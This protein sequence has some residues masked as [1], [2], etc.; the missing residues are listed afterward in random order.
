MPSNYG[1]WEPVYFEVP[2]TDTTMN[3]VTHNTTQVYPKFPMPRQPTAMTDMWWGATRQAS[4]YWH[5]DGKDYKNLRN[6]LASKAIQDR[7]NSGNY[8]RASRPHLHAQLFREYGH[9]LG[10]ALG[11][12]FKCQDQENLDA[13]SGALNCLGELMRASPYTRLHDRVVHKMQQTTPDVFVCECCN[14]LNVGER[15]PAYHRFNVFYCETCVDREMVVPL[16]LE[17][18][19]LNTHSVFRFRDFED[20]EE[21]P[22]AYEDYYV[23][24]DY[25]QS[26]TLRWAGSIER[27]ITRAVNALMHT[28]GP[29]DGR[30]Y[31]Y[32]DGPEMGHIPSAYDNRQPRVLMGLELEVEVD[33]A[34][35]DDDSPLIAEVAEDCI[36]TANR[37]VTRYM[38]AEHDGSLDAGFEMITGWTGLDVHEKVLRELTKLPVWRGLRSH[39]TST[40][41]LHVHIDRRGMTPLHVVKL[42]T[43]INSKENRGLIKCISRRYSTNYAK[44]HT[45][46][47]WLR[48]LPTMFM[49]AVRQH[50]SWNNVSHNEVVKTTFDCGASTSEMQRD[51]YSALN[52]GNHQTVEFRMFRG[53]TKLTTIMACLEFA[54]AAWHFTR[55]TPYRNLSE[56]AFIEF[57]CAPENRKDTKY[58][59]SYLHDK[60]FAKFYEY[61]QVMR[62]KDKRF[63]EPLERVRDDAIRREHDDSNQS[64]QELGEALR[65]LRA[66]QRGE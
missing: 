22:L 1:P 39:D 27:Y 20:Y 26:R 19:Y 56:A 43:F 35:S 45:D 9:S 65:D 16:R 51:R 25:V 36:N 37:L 57:I 33:A 28:R 48:E 30:I 58:L 38:K 3:Y 66:A 55:V 34:D 47:D 18:G 13:V 61:E 5:E 14:G 53:S 52:W 24:Q 2:Q 54:F 62:P 42:Q 32:H 44:V 15:Y 17:E 6:A 49:Q 64:L 59:R 8:Q 23:S 31:D 50:A 10:E 11:S 46:R 7:I 12:F 41:G 63:K 21:N 40:C 60:R 4:M 29:I